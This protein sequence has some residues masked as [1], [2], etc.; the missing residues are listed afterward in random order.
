MRVAADL[1]FEL[2]AYIPG[3][4]AKTSPTDFRPIEHLQMMRFTG[5]RWEWFGPLLDGRT[6]QATSSPG[7]AR[8]SCRMSRRCLR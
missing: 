6:D 3:V 4:R 2:E 5:E 8:T 1:D 7:S